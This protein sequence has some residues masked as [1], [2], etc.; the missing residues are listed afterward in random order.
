VAARPS[1]AGAVF[2]AL[3]DPERRA[4]YVHGP[5]EGQFLF[6]LDCLSRPRGG[7]EAPSRDRFEG[8]AAWGEAAAAALTVG[9]W[10]GPRLVVAR[11][12]GRPSDEAAAAL[13][14]ALAGP[15][16]GVTLV[17]RDPGGELGAGVR[18]LRRGPAAVA[19]AELAERQ[20]AA[21]A[22][23]AGTILG[24][25]WTPSVAARLVQ[26]T[27][28][29]V[30]RVLPELAKLAD[31]LPDGRVTE[32]EVDALVP[33]WPTA[34]A[35]ALADA[36]LRADLR[37]ALAAVADGLRAGD[38]PFALLGLAARQVRLLALAWEVARLSGRPA[39]AED[40]VEP[41][42]LGRMA[43]QAQAFARAAAAGRPRPEGA[44]TALLEADGDLKSDLPPEVA[45]GRL[46]VRLIGT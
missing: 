1:E 10:S 20:V 36:Y 43:F 38:V 34:R 22:H 14:R 33:E 24:L 16:A 26:R 25:N 2:A 40:L 7:Q 5:D 15:A 39:R 41:L 13:A 31:V 17:V 11:P 28:P 32:G 3:A 30:L 27:G 46:M 45:L 23:Q 35:F 18:G 44:W 19:A 9:L 4:F 42:G 37:G 6:L 21:F 29:S 8:P 12:E